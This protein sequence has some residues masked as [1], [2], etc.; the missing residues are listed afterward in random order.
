MTKREKQLQQYRQK[1]SER[2]RE[3]IKMELSTVKEDAKTDREQRE[4]AEKKVS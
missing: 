3:C 4:K 2:E 1:P